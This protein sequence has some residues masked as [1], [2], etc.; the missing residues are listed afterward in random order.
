MFDPARMDAQ[1]RLGELEIWR[2]G[3]DLHHP[4]HVHLS[5]F[6]VI[7]RSGRGPGPF[8]GGW[9]DTVDVRPAEHVDVAVRF[10]EKVPHALPQPRA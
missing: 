6:Q 5:P 8:D 4:V 3:T 2:F 1:L 9:K 7:G 10:T